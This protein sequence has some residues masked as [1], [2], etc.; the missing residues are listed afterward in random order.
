[1]PRPDFLAS[2]TNAGSWSS[3]STLSVA[4]AAISP[5]PPSM[6]WLC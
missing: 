1:M 6:E 5:S 2:S 3:E 4:S